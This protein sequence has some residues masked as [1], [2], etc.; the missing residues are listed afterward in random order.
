METF[1]TSAI[2]KPKTL[3][4]LYDQLE[5]PPYGVKRGIIPILLAALLLYHNDDVSVY[6]DGI[7]IPVL[8]AEHFELLVKYP[9]RFAVKYFEIVGVRSQVFRELEAILKSSNTKKVTAKVRNVTM[10]SV[11]KP[12]FQFAK[13]LKI[14][15][16]KTK[17]I[18][19]EAQ[20]VVQALQKAQEPDELI[21]TS[22][23]IAC[24]LEPI[25]SG[26]SEDGAA[27]AKQF[28][29]KLVQVLHE[30][31]NSYD[32]L[33]AHCHS[34]L[35]E[36]FGVRG[37]GQRLREDLGVRASYLTDGCIERTLKR[38]V[39]A[40]ADKTAEDKT[41]L[42]SLLMIVA[43]KPAE[44]WND[45]DEIGFESKL[46]DLA[47]RFINLEALQKGM[48][49]SKNKGFDARRIT[50][51]R[52]DGYEVHRLLWLDPDDSDLLNVEIDEILKKPIFKDSERL[53]QGLIALLAEKVLN[54]QIA[55]D[56]APISAKVTN[57]KH[58]QIVS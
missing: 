17:R 50:I 11:V 52:P 44:S 4:L 30:I 46:S 55:G 38:F 19:S 12:L 47:R 14:Y 35:H 5:S 41:W 21:F 37:G 1:C 28:K 23:P 49:A 2:A 53:K 27:I 29:G 25:V 16:T 15:T 56:V 33:L 34:L 51:G 22:L 40:A 20:A 39:L 58:S 26:V 9:Q 45:A 18:S 13:N 43:D 3:N 10:L 31:Q 6:K 36:A 48:A 57:L 7:F 8:G 54:N 42:E 32:Q 24:G